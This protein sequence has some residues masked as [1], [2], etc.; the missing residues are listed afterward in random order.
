MKGEDSSTPETVVSQNV[1]P[2]RT[3]LRNFLNLVDNCEA[4][5]NGGVDSYDKEFQ[6]RRTLIFN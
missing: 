2:L 4:R 6:V 1:V 3:I 5:R